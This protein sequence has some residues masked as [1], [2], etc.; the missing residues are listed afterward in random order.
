M[1]YAY[2]PVKDPATGKIWKVNY[3][4]FRKLV[5]EGNIKETSDGYY[6]AKATVPVI[7][8]EEGD[9]KVV[10]MR[11]DLVPRDYMAEHPE[12]DLAA[13][14]KKKNSRAKNPETQRP[15]GFD[16]FNARKE[17]L[18]SRPAFRQSWKERLRCVMPAV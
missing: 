6:Y 14:L 11:W 3:R 16:S 12:M 15:W 2:K 4:D 7:I 5:Q 1:C 9:Y 10:P 8:L 13:V 17:T 18:A